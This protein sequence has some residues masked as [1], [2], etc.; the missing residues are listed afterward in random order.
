MMAYVWRKNSNGTTTYLGSSSIWGTWNAGNSSCYNLI[1]TPTVFGISGV[2]ATTDYRF[3]LSARTY[4]TAGNSS[5]S[6]T[7]NAI[8]SEWQ[9]Q[10]SP[11]TPGAMWSSCVTAGDRQ[12]V[13]THDGSSESRGTRV[14]LPSAGPFA[15]PAP[16]G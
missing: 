9:S 5:S 13:D 12:S 15:F 16:R 7:V 3:A 14:F 11:P 8:K 1:Q 10:W 6:Y 4:T 2:G